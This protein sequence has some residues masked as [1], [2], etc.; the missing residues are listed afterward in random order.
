MRPAGK[1]EIKRPVNEGRSGFGRAHGQQD[2]GQDVTS[3]PLPQRQDG[4]LSMALMWLCPDLK[5]HLMKFVSLL[6][7]LLTTSLCSNSVFF[8]PSD[9]PVIILRA[10]GGNV[11]SG[12]M[13]RPPALP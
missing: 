2:D 7:L 6:G 12:V 11:K 9:P 1:G 13:W 4:P 8:S 3:G 5:S 10:L